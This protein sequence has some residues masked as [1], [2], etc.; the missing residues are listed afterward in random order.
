MT[1]ALLLKNSV[2]KKR[3]NYFIGLLIE[4]AYS[5][6]E[7]KTIKKAFNLAL[8]MHKNQKR[9]SGE[10]YIIHPLETA[11]F[12][13]EWKM[14]LLTIILGL[15]HD[16]L[17][18]TDV[19]ANTIIKLFGQ[20]TFQL[21]EVISK[22]SKTSAHNR[23]QTTDYSDI[24]STY[25]IKII[26]NISKDL[27]PMIVKIADRMHNMRTISFLK[28]EKQERIAQETF[29]VFA[30]IAGRMGLYKQKTELL[31]LSFQV[32]KPTAFTTTKKLIEQL[33]DKYHKHVQE[34]VTKLEKILTNQK[35]DITYRIKGVYSTYKKIKKGL[36]IK[37]IN[38][39]FA[40]RIIGNFTEIKC[41]EI[42]GLIHLNFV[43]LPNSFK[44]YI[45]NPKLNLYQSLHTTIIYQGIMLEIQIRTKNMD[46]T[47]NYGLAAHWLYKQQSSQNRELLYSLMSDLWNQNKFNLKAIELNQVYDVLVLN[48]SKW[49]VIN[50]NHTVVDLAF[51]YNPRKVIY[52]EHVYKENIKVPFNYHPLKNDIISFHYANTPQA[53]HNWTQYVTIPQAQAVFAKIEEPKKNNIPKEILVSFVNKNELKKRLAYLHFTNLK[54]YLSFFHNKVDQT[55]LYGFLSKKPT[56]KK[57]YLLLNQ[58]SQQDVFS[59]YC[60]QN[61]PG[62]QYRQAVFSTCCSK[63]PYMKI[64]GCLQKN[65]LYIHKHNC[66][67]IPKNPKIYVLTWDIKKL[68]ANKGLSFY[69]AKIIL[70]HPFLSINMNQI[71]HY[72]TAQGFEIIFFQTFADKKTK[73]TTIEIKVNTYENIQELINQLYYRFPAIKNIVFW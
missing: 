72:I 4:Q 16:L 2:V 34:V 65:N 56:W 32:L 25:L 67:K 3:Y 60:L 70:F 68:Q 62:V 7:L 37:D 10:P 14:D 53:Q 51:L 47:A 59:N 42:L 23:A 30:N 9:K 17:E 43:F 22:V 45:S 20:Q 66:I 46:Y 28:K 11:I 33:N 73:T 13:A 52:L 24:N 54:S 57:D 41:Y 49:Y 27:R 8:L 36:A 18:D 29:N 1:I 71:I 64:I 55:I 61:L 69:N 21:L 35:N 63:I 58:I 48:N 50:Q 40:I 19:E 26:M 39:V 5:K 38:D 6:S 44:D 15:L 31:D 12:L